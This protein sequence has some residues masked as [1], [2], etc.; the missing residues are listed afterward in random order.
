MSPLPPLVTIPILNVG[1]SLN[2]NEGID[3]KLGKYNIF[4]HFSRKNILAEDMSV[5]K[6]KKCYQN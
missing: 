2:I 4:I 6:I 5:Y 3:L 1:L